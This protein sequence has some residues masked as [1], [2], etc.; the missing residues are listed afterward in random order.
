MKRTLLAV[1]LLVGCGETEQAVETKTSALLV[2]AAPDPLDPQSVDVNGD[3][4][5]SAVGYTWKGGEVVSGVSRLLITPPAGLVNHHAQGIAYLAT[6]YNHAGHGI[7]CP[8]FNA[9][10]YEGWFDPEPYP[11][12]PHPRPDTFRGQQ[13]YW[14][15][16]QPMTCTG[17]RYF[18]PW[19]G[20]LPSSITVPAYGIYMFESAGQGGAGVP[21]AFSPTL[22]TRLVSP[23][24]QY[25][26]LPEFA[27]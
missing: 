19:F 8:S 23:E 24:L 1:L 25:T 3:N 21:V 17:W 11:H 4:R 15:N 9:Y 7:S 26:W 14:F 27:E 18:G 2:T 13:G 22:L 5:Y 12:V 10:Y 6:I 20:W 16:A